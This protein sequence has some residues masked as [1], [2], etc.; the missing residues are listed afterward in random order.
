MPNFVKISFQ[1]KKFSIQGLNFD[2]LVC[3]ATICYNGAISAVPTNG[4]LLRE[5]II[6]RYLKLRDWFAYIQTDGHG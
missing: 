5:K 3:M 4:Q 6:D 1:M 2:R